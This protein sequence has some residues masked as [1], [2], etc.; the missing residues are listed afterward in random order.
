MR[1]KD[2]LERTVLNPMVMAGKPAGLRGI[3]HIMIWKQ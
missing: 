3:E 1:D 2:L